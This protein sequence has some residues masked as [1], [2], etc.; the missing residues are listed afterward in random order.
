[1]GAHMLRR[2]S[3]ISFILFTLLASPVSAEV[4]GSESYARF[5]PENHFRISEG[6]F[7]SNTL[8]EARYH[9]I[10]DRIER[11]YGP[12]IKA[13]G[14]KLVMDR[15]W[16]NATVNAYAW[17]SGQSWMV[18]MCGGLARHSVLTEDGFTLVTCHE[19]GHH[20]G[21]SPKDLGEWLSSDGQSD[22]FATLKCLRKVWENDDSAS[23]V[24]KIDVDSGIRR[25]CEK[26][27]SDLNSISICIRSAYAGL[28][29]ANLAAVL[30]EEKNPNFN[31][32]DL[33][34]VGSTLTSH[35]K[36]QCR[37]DTFVSGSL[38][39]VKWEDELSETNSLAGSCAME[40]GAKIGYRPL[41]WYK[42]RI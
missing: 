33:S 38:C 4:N 26:S 3:M 28:S 29:A 34:K 16:G 41:C 25:N 11:A 2:K 19:L 15:A 39:P 42:P 23:V 31:T 13:K 36:A 40:T 5:L 9:S 7:E 30:S 20:L 12:V 17:R 37:L 1:M 6:S 21:G 24:S 32:P 14:G 27:F 8:T 10:L 35:P 22:Y 18:Q